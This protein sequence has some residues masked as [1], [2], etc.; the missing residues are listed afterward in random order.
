[1]Y[2]CR[3]TDSFRITEI[4]VT[5]EGVERITPINTFKDAGLHPAMDRNIELCGY[6]TPTPIQR[7]CIPTIKLGYDVLA[8]AQTGQ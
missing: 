7:Y 1:M 3:F 2:I 6:K 8:I 5:Q 4:K